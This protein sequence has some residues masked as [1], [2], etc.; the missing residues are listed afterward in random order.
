MR[1]SIIFKLL[2]KSLP[3]HYCIV[4]IASTIYSNFS[5]IVFDCSWCY[6]CMGKVHYCICCCFAIITSW[7]HISTNIVI[8]PEYCMTEWM[9]SILESIYVKKR[10][11][12]SYIHRIISCC[13]YFKPSEYRVLCYL[14]WFYL[15]CW[16]SKRLIDR[17]WDIF[18]FSSWWFYNLLHAVSDSLVIPR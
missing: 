12:E 10:W 15:I 5:S 16:T 6:S 8:R 13:C 3:M 7:V 18:D 11:Y 1:I 14:A 4:V 9:M 2:W 17:Y